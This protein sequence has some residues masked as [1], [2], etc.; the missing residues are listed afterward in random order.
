MARSTYLSIIT[1]KC[2]LSKRSDQKTEWLNRY[3]SKIHIHGTYKRLTSDLK[4]DQE[5]KWGWKMVFH[6][7]KNES[8]DKEE[9]RQLTLKHRL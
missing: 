9:I 7:N 8:K 4:K 3:K 6:G 5:W 2:Q 1:F